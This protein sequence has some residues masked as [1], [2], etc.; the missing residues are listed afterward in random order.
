MGCN[1]ICL[2][3]KAKCTPS[4]G[5][6]RNGQKRCPSCNIYLQYDGLHCPCCR[7]K[8][9]TKP[10]N[11][12]FKEKT[13]GRYKELND[14]CPGCGYVMQNMYVQRK[15]SNGKRTTLRTGSMCCFDCKIEKSSMKIII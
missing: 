12:I 5:R 8:L 3:Y 6:Y 14:K 11:K 15:N 7:Y 13:R 2:K 10:R 9:R 1:Q 4:E